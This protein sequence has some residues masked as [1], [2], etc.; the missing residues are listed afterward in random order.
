MLEMLVYPVSAVIKLWHWLL[1]DVL[2]M[3]PSA[4]W[5][6]SVILLVV[7]VRALIMP[8]ALQQYRISRVGFLVRPHLARIK[9]QYADATSPEAIAAEKQAMKKVQDEHNYNPLAGCIPALIQFPVFIGL[10]RLLRWMAVPTDGD[11]HTIGILTPQ[12][13][14]TF[15]AASLFDAPLPAYMAMPP[16]H[17]AAL[18]A[19]EAQVRAVALPMVIAAVIFT[20]SNLAISQMRNRSTLDWENAMT[21]KSYGLLWWAIPLIALSLISAGL[22]GIV[23]IAVLLYWV[24]G[25]LW[26]MTQ[27]ILFWAWTVRRYPAEALHRE[28]WAE[29]KQ[30]AE[31]LRAARKERTRSRRAK[32]LRALR[33]PGEAGA[34]AREL[35]AEKRE[36]KQEKAREKQERKALQKARNEASRQLARDKKRQKQDQME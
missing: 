27:T 17:L 21:R 36:R 6:A 19:T 7:T 32:R 26:T 24:T 8:F 20:C 30:K 25:N 23:P 35:R 22:S 2:G 16:E 9:A 18:G 33:N 10:Y 1:A 31:E 34:I 11:N 13:L 12:D 15:R 14:E 4:A 28:F 29:T 3:G 5:V